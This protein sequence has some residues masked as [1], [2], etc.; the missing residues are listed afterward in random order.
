VR[1]Y[2][3]L[4]RIF[5]VVLTEHLVIFYNEFCFLLLYRTFPCV[6]NLAALVKNIE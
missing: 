5:N 1:H 6:E 4:A 3:E 2:I